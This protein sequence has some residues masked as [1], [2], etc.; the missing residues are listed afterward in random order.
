MFV[1]LENKDLL[2]LVAGSP[3]TCQR[4]ALQDQGFSFGGASPELHF[5]IQASRAHRSEIR[6]GKASH[7]ESWF[8]LGL[9][10][11]GEFKQVATNYFQVEKSL[12]QPQLRS[13]NP[14][15]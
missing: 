7:E 3:L 5:L 4:W 1:C 6:R 14:L 11:P 10:K 8:S 2:L 15:Q 12:F 9:A 13:V